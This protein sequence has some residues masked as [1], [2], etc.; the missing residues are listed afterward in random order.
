M[1]NEEHA[2]RLERLADIE[3]AHA[4]QCEARAKG[5]SGSHPLESKGHLA[6][7]ADFIAYADALRA[8]AAAL[9]GVEGAKG[10]LLRVKEY[11][12]MSHREDASEVCRDWCPSCAIDAALK[13]MEG[14]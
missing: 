5:C 13:R 1:T 4:K 6:N 9:R 3:E 7:A 14:E 10:A 11:G 12:G 2:A 8:G